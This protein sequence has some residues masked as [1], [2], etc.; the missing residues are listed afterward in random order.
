MSLKKY[1]KFNDDFKSSINIEYDYNDSDKVNSYIL[2]NSNIDALKFYA[3]NIQKSKNRAN[4]LIGAY[5]KGK[6]NLLLVL[7]NIFGFL[8]CQW[9]YIIVPYSN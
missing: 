4:I 6:S 9:T 8:I 7:L 3:N 1:I 5:G 2:T